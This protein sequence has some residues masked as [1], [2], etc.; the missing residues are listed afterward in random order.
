[1]GTVG[2]VKYVHH[3]IAPISLKAQNKACQLFVFK[4]SLAIQYTGIL[5]LPLFFSCRILQCFSFHFILHD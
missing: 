3:D 2:M 5:N 4:T 1:M